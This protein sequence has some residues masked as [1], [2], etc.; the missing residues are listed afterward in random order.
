M[1]YNRIVDFLD[2]NYIFSVA[3]HGFRAGR[4]TE[5]AACEFMQVV[6]KH[7]DD[8]RCVAGLFF[9]LSRAFDSLEVNF[10]LEKLSVSGIRGGMLNVLASY[11]TDRT[12]YVNVENK[13]S[14][15][16]DV[17]IGVPQGSV[18]GS[19]LF[20]LFINDMPNYIE[21]GK[22]VMFADDSSVVVSTGNPDELSK[23]IE[24]VMKDFDCWCKM[25]NLILNLQKTVYMNFRCRLSTVTTVVDGIQAS[26]SSKF[27]GL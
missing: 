19:L 21:H 7:L 22:V 3:Q 23:L 2:K 17:D 5:S 12:F 11:L 1:Y 10:V 8:G 24:S 16:K 4:S 18:L 25:N 15:M 9:D 13:C 26:N 20:L 27:L 14:G 6:Y